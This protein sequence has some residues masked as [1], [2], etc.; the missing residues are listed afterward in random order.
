MRKITSEDIE[1]HFYNLIKQDEL[2]TIKRIIELHGFGS[3]NT[4]S[5]IL[6]KLKLASLKLTKQKVDILFEVEHSN[7]L[8]KLS[9]ELNTERDEKQQAIKRVAL[10]NDLVDELETSLELS[11]KNNDTLQ[12]AYN[13]LNENFHFAEKKNKAQVFKLQQIEKENNELEEALDLLQA[14][15]TS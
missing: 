7:R 5:P 14:N 9:K 2:P 8:E 6:K 3:A 10:L 12:K 1:K 4:I 13:L 11:Q 15:E